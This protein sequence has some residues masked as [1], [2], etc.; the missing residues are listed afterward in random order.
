MMDQDDVQA[1]QWQ[2]NAFGATQPPEQDQSLD[3]DDYWFVPPYTETITLGEQL[4]T[5]SKDSATHLVYKK[6]Q[7]RVDIWGPPDCIQRA[8]HALNHFAKYYLEVAEKKQK[9]KKTKGWAK[10]ERELTPS[11]KRKKE[12]EEKRRL[13]R[14]KYLGMPTESCKY[15]HFINWPKDLPAFRLFGGSLH[16]L[17]PL[18]NEFQCF[19]WMDQPLL[20]FAGND[21]ILIRTAVN[22]VKNYIIKRIN[23]FNGTMCHIL[24][25][26]SKLVEINILDAPLVPYIYLPEQMTPFRPSNQKVLP[27][28]FLIATE[29]AT[30]GSLRDLDLRMATIGRNSDTAHQSGAD[31]LTPITNEDY[32]Q[33]MKYSD[34]MMEGN[35]EKIRNSLEQALEHVQLMDGDIKMRIQ[36]GQVA[37]KTYPER[38]TWDVKELD[39]KIIPDNRLDTDFSPFITDSSE[40]F[41]A[42][43]KRLTPPN[44]ERPDQPEMLW[45]LGIL[46]R[47]EVTNDPIEV[48]L[49]ITFRDDDKVAFWNALVQ[50]TTPLDI[51]VISSERLFSWAWN[52]SAGKRL[53]AD[54]FSQEGKFVHELHLEKRN[55]QDARLVYSNTN[56]VQLRHVKREKKWSFLREPWTIELTEVAIW[57]FRSPSKPYQKLTLSASPDEILYSVSMYRDSWMA[58]MCENPH[59]GLGQ[60]PAWEPSD[61]FQDEEAISNTMENIAEIR[62]IIEGVF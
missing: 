32:F 26:P 10:P 54:K 23:Q 56:D 20:N 12:R 2:T 3:C 61:F 15:N 24:E 52:I 48:H 34:S 17:D 55:G 27:E 57:T 18:R 49:D 28:K 51:R 13:E 47:N 45:T 4:D 35:I 40:K 6:Q 58:R 29:L 21:E 16:L 43:V 7:E 30:F 46:R 38:T 14:E 44:Q 31:S 25:K 22:R 19:I 42:L 11:E 37:L 59:L 62:N 1:Q 8:K 53:D 9:A 36:F 33:S 5:I 39:S 41:S 50:K 60:L